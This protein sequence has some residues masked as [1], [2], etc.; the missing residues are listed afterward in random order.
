MR[1]PFKIFSITNNKISLL[2]FVYST[3][4]IDTIYSYNELQKNLKMKITSKYIN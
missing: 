2:S 1:K 4:Y 3:I